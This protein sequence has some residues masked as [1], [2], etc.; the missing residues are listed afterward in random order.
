MVS[1][2]EDL[3]SKNQLVIELLES[4]VG[5]NIDQTQ[6]LLENFEVALEGQNAVIAKQGTKIK[7]DIQ[8]KILLLNK[9]LDQFY[10]SWTEKKP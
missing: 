7:N 9:E 6:N 3:I 2:F 8:Q 10:L 4:D 5:F 1:E